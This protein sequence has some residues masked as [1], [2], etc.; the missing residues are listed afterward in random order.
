MKKPDI[1]GKNIFR[2]LDMNG[3]WRY[4]SLIYTTTGNTKTWLGISARGNGGWFNLIQRAYVKPN[5]V[6]QFTGRYDEKGTPVY[7]GDYLRCYDTL[8]KVR[9]EG[10][11]DYADCS[12]RINSDFITHYRWMDYEVEVIGNIHENP[13]LL[14]RGDESTTQSA[15]MSAT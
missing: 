2:G 1:R 8:N 11:V 3:Q 9:F 14:E 5:T 12:F 10:Y 15:L 7:E 4:G 13:H 6:G